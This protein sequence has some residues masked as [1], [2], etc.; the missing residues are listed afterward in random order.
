MLSGRGT[1]A[2]GERSAVGRGRSGRVVGARY[3]TDDDRPR[4][5][6]GSR[7]RAEVGED[8][9]CVV[10]ERKIGELLNA[11]L[12][13]LVV[14]GALRDWRVERE[15]RLKRRFVLSRLARTRRR[16]VRRAGRDEHEQCGE[17]AAGGGETSEQI[18][19]YE[20][21]GGPFRRVPRGALSV[22][23][24]NCGRGNCGGRLRERLVARPN[25]PCL[26]EAARSP[27]TGASHS[28]NLVA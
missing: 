23:L 5:T 24:A 27:L 18:H 21:R 26:V 2:A 22:P 7:R 20:Y 28:Y 8:A 16:H 1:Q 3:C 17:N 13:P 9:R 25:Q 4:V 10:G 14:A 19:C 11:A 15:G 12:R 6:D